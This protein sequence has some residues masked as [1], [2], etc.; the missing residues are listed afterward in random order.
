MKGLAGVLTLLHDGGYDDEAAIRWLHTA[1]RVAARHPGRRAAGGPEPGGQAAGP[2]DGA[3]MRVTVNG[4]RSRAAGRHRPG[5][6]AG[7]AGPAR[8][9]GRRRA[10]RRGAG[11]LGAGR[12]RAGRRR[13]AGAGPRGR[14]WIAG[15]PARGAPGSTCARTGAATAATWPSS[16]TPRCAAASTSCSCGRRA[17]E[18]RDGARA[19]G[20]VRRRRPPARRAL[21][22]QRPGRPRRGRR[23]G[24]AAPRPGR[25]AGAGRAPARRAGPVVGRS[26]HD[27]AQVDA[28]EVEP[29]VD[30]FCVG[31]TWPTPTK[32]GRPAAR[33]GPDP[34]RGRRTRPGPGSPSAASTPSGST[35]C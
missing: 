8:R 28:A 22:G 34:V 13:P 16:S 18:A 1:G 5:R 23:R 12:G 25:P 4:G 27:R 21:V 14:R 3:L 20:G 19:A 26:T 17:C 35:R 33:P 30:Y 24:R 11:P 31:P 10:Q 6:A 9:L 29:G 32:P 15:R 2:G 7:A